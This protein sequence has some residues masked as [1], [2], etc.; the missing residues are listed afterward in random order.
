MS[1]SAARRDR[2]SGLRRTFYAVVILAVIG[3][4]FGEDEGEARLPEGEGALIERLAADADADAAVVRV[5][6]P[7]SHDDAALFAEEVDAGAR[8]LVVLDSTGGS[9]SAAL[10][11]GRLVRERALTTVVEGD[12]ECLSACAL[13]WLAGEPRVAVGGAQIGFHAAYLSEDDDTLVERGAP[14]ALIGAYLATLG[15][16]ESLIWEATLAAPDEIRALS[17]AF[18]E[19][20]GLRYVALPAGTALG[21]VRGLSGAPPV[22]APALVAVSTSGAGAATTRYTTARWR[23]V[24]AAGTAPPQLV[25][26]VSVPER[27]GDF[28][29]TLAQNT[30]ETFDAAFVVSL[31][32]SGAEPVSAITAFETRGAGEEIA[33]VAAPYTWQENGVSWLSLGRRA[34]RRA[35]AQR[36]TQAQDFALHF[37]LDDGRTAVVALSKGANWTPALASAFT[38]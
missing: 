5:S 4:V 12:G 7:L 11:M 31:A 10:A 37:V 29:I 19:R 16:T 32:A 33:P 18:A 24:G 17:P 3:A 36:L 13:V 26:S 20:T 2:W 21:E 25:A 23:L 34:G 15:F 38:H 14:N 35:L 27:P 28:T 22:S 8:P 6:G 9:V 1:A 30:D